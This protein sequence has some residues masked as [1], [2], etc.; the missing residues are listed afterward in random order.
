M[1]LKYAILIS[2]LLLLMN[3]TTSSLASD[4]AS[5]DST[6]EDDQEM[7]V[8]IYQREL[9]ENNPSI[10][11]VYTDHEPIIIEQLS[12]FSNYSSIT[13]NGTEI[14]PYRIEGLNITT[15]A[16]EY[17]AIYITGISSV[18]IVINGCYIKTSMESSQYYGIHIHAVSSSNVTIISN[19]LENN[20]YAIRVSTTD[21][22]GIINNTF[23]DNKYG[24]IVYNSLNSIVDNNSITGTLNSAIELIN[25]VSGTYDQSYIRFN[26][27]TNSG[28][29]V[30]IDSSSKISLS[31][32][33]L[34]LIQY[35][36]TLI[37]S[38]LIRFYQNIIKDTTYKA[39]IVEY[40]TYTEITE[41]I[42]KNSGTEGIYLDNDD[43]SYITKNILI[44][45]KE[46]AIYSTYSS[47]FAIFSNTFINN[48]HYTSQCYQDNE[49][50]TNYWYDEDESEGNYYSDY[51]GVGG[52]SI[53]GGDDAEDPYPVTELLFSDNIDPTVSE[54]SYT[55]VLPN[56]EDLIVVSVIAED[57]IAVKNVTLYYR[58]TNESLWENNV[59]EKVNTANYSYTIGPAEALEEVE[60]Y[61]KTYDYA[62]NMVLNSTTSILIKDGTS[63]IIENITYSPTEPTDSEE[64]IISCTVNDN[65]AID[66]VFVSFGEFGDV[67]TNITLTFNG[68]YFVANIGS[69][70]ADTTIY[71]FVTANDTTGN[72][73]ESDISNFT[74]SASIPEYTTTL[75]SIIGSIVV[76]IT[77]IA[78]SRKI[79]KK[80]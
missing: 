75:L 78:V 13:G 42:I 1:R 36:L 39:I 66:H 53:D 51:A 45:N 5:F 27:I 11:E 74:V 44:E 22:V 72:T 19:V 69:F 47:L 16:T 61:V 76:S 18:N 32:N 12:D 57:N 10:T 25:I 7:L 65:I 43:N 23:I 54:I 50:S 3:L 20:N 24:L 46:Y 2:L 35:A 28:S 59:M 15:N 8:D 31:N 73:I 33:T 4:I 21:N 67:W 52:Y 14:S 29:G 37:D 80:I 48:G 40:S 9:R 62:E 68:T 56:S 38:D 26:K 64:V 63:P 77:I 6:L 58:L 55:P 41:N 30:I 34:T 79:G 60:F 70:D 17:K 49:R 71:F